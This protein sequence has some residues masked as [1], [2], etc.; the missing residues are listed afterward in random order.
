[1]PSSVLVGGMR[2]SVTTTSGRSRSIVS[3]RLSRSPTA[4]TTSSFG[5]A[6]SASTMPRRTRNES[7]PTTTRRR[8]SVTRR[9]SA[10]PSTD[11][12]QLGSRTWPSSRRRERAS[13]CTRPW[14]SHRSV[15]RASSEYCTTVRAV[16]AAPSSV[17]DRRSAG[18]SR[19]HN[20]G[21][22]QRRLRSS[23]DVCAMQE[24][25][26]CV[27]RSMPPQSQQPMRTPPDPAFGRRGAA[28]RTVPVLRERLVS[29]TALVNRLRTES[30]QLITLVAPAGYGKTTLLTQW[31]LRDTRTFVWLSLE[32]ED[33]DPKLLRALIAS[34]V[35][36]ATGEEDAPAELL[37]NRTSA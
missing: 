32:A 30:A 33:D 35:A 27:G 29:R 12:P 4:A 8:P 13:Q 15:R 24:R 1:M 10:C 22:G 3:R 6:E 17:V 21:G 28:V 5:L 26:A 16:P 19:Q 9:P 36:D 11:S 18:A 14:F 23:P 37:D 7:S 31:A 2:M 20:C 34:A 25:D